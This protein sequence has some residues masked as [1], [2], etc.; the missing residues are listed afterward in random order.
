VNVV[1]RL[2]RDLRYAVRILLK[3]PVATLVAILALALGI[4]VN[5][6]AF[7]TISSLI[8][9]PLPY[10][11][12]ERIVT[13]WETPPKLH[14]QQS[15][16]APGNFIDLRNETHSFQ[17]LAAYRAWDA[18]LTG[19][20][21]PERLQACLVS[22]SFFSVLGTSPELGR[23]FANDEDQPSRSR[24]AVVSEGFW[25]SRLAGSK[26]AMGSSI[27]LNQRSYTVVGVMPDRFD[28][29]LGTEVWSPLTFEAAEQ[30][31]RASHNLMVLGLLKP[32]V[33]AA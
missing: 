4:G 16:F 33:S 9:H 17:K 20:G 32:E 7:I 14:A 24:V 8:L 5:A 23:V 10:A 12:L 2:V 13:I 19:I 21:T 22:P 29:P 25:K 27:Y 11:H 18:N 26:A 28:Y 31:E 30:H 1:Y 3:S 6:S 15:A